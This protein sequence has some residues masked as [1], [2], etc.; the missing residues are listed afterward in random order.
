MAFDDEPREKLKV[1]S[2]ATSISVLLKRGPRS[3]FIRAAHKINKDASRLVEPTYPLRH[4]PAPE[5]TNRACIFAR[6]SHPQ[7]VGRRPGRTVRPAAMTE[8]VA[9]E[10]CEQT[11]FE[12]QA[13]FLEWRREKGR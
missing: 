2:P 8:R 10:A 5:D 7:R 4:A 3:V 11:V 13:R 1:A 9:N 12:A 6:R